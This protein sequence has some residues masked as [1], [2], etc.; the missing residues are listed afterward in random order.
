MK[1]SDLLLNKPI[2]PSLYAASASKPRHMLD[3]KNEVKQAEA[4]NRY[5]AAMS[6]GERTASEIAAY[7]NITVGAAYCQL[8][9]MEERHQVV[10]RVDNESGR[11]A[12]F[13]RFVD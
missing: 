10:R 6:R 12:T 8:V 2:P 3:E 13:W 7:L 5:R 1:F 11:R 4:L 9:R